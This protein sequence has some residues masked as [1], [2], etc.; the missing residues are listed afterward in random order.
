MAQKRSYSFEEIGERRAGEGEGGASTWSTWQT[1]R[2]LARRYSCRRTGS[3]DPSARF[4]K[5]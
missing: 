4:E 2:R 3:F 1:F 5:S